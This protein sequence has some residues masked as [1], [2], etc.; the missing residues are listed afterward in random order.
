MSSKGTVCVRVCMSVHMCTY[1]CKCSNR[2]PALPPSTMP[3]HILVVSLHQLHWTGPCLFGDL[4]PDWCRGFPGRGCPYDHQPHGHPDRIH[5]RD[6][7]RASHYDHSDGEHCL[8]GHFGG[9][10]QAH[11]T[12]AS[13]QVFTLC[14][15]WPSGQGTFSIRAFTTST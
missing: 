15:R 11:P 2:S 7:L 12:A 4:C 3:S 8:L 10:R 6:H 14:F 1:M 9:Q 5:Q 13:F